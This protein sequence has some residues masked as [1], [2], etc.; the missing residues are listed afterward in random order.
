MYLVRYGE[1]FLKSERTKGLWRKALGRQIKRAF[2]K[3]PVFWGFGMCLDVPETRENTRKLQ[4]IFGIHS[5]SPCLRA[6]VSDL[7][8]AVVDFVRKRKEGKRTFAIRVKGEG[9][10]GELTRKL[11]GAVRERFPELEVRARK[12]DLGIHVEIRGDS[13]F[14]Y[15]EILKGAGGLPPGVE[16][17]VVALLSPGVD[18]PVAAWLMMKRG[19][20]VIPLHIDLEFSP[21]LPEKMERIVGMLREYQPDMELRTIKMG[22]FI[23]RLREFLRERRAESYT[24]ILCRRRMYREAQKVASEEGARGIVTGEALGQAASQTLANLQVIDECVSLPVYRPLI[25]LDKIEIEKL[26]QKIGTYRISASPP[27]IPCPFAPLH[28]ETKAFLEKI[29]QLERDF[30]S[31]T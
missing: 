24:C 19:C 29:R 23:R 1:L 5:F 2:G 6:S 11:V 3:G 31:L 18:S 7:E 22:D 30:E 9:P 4:K 15:S 8:E 13:A 10:G 20:L 12:P 26:A 28:P 25:G 21:Y 14:I 27:H 17:K 16:G